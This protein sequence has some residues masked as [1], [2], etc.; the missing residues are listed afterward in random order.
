[1]LGA[2]SG[3]QPGTVARARATL[4]DV[5]YRVEM[6]AAPGHVIHADEPPAMGG[7]GTAPG[8]Y[9][10]V[11]TGLAACTVITLRMYE[12][13]KHWDLGAISVEL[14]LERGD[15][16]TERVH[17]RVWVEGADAEQL[18]RLGEIAD[19][20]PVTLTLARGMAI[21]TEIAA[22]PPAQR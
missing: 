2:M 11:L 18:A 10:L 14:D 6:Q 21:T 13:R 16:L 20:T 19:R 8:P 3:P 17:R 7:A 15:D 1:M 9:D 22:A 12:Q 4:A 5:D